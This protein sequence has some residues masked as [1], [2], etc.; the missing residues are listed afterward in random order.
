MKKFIVLIALLVLYSSCSDYQKALKSDD[1]TTK[2][3]AASKQFDKGKYSKAIRI[4][5]QIAPAFKGKPQAEKMFYMFSESYYKTKQY[6]LAGYQYESFASSYPKSEK[7]E[8]ASFL[9]AKCYSMLS[10]VYS[11]DQKDTDKA[12]DKLQNFIDRYPN[13]NYMDE[14]NTIMKSLKTKLEKKSFENAKQY[15]SIS[16]YKSAIISLDNFISDFPGTPFKEEALYYK[17]DSEYMLA[18]NS[19]N[20]KMEERLKNA[21]TSYS[22]LIKFNAN[23]KFKSKAD[24]MLA[25]IESDLQQF[26]K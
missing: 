24:I 10:P 13:S 20:T 23:T 9:G 17:F 8:E 3:E 19:I 12:I 15:N 1:V 5:E 6:Y 16:D 21:K 25:K 26:S 18:I 22:N 4:F 11:L 7:H 14:A 2:F